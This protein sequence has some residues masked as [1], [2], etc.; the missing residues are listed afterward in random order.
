[1]NPISTSLK[2]LTQGNPDKLFPAENYKERLPTFTLFLNLQEMTLT[3]YK[4][5]KAVPIK[6]SYKRD[7]TVEMT[8][9]YSKGISPACIKVLLIMEKI[10]SSAVEIEIFEENAAT[11]PD[12]QPSLD[13]SFWTRDSCRFNAYLNPEKLMITEEFNKNSADRLLGLK[14]FQ[15]KVLEKVNPKIGEYVIYEK[16]DIS[17][18]AKVTG[19]KENTFELQIEP[20]QLF[21]LPTIVSVDRKQIVGKLF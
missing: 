13:D 3:S 9:S 2:A 6:Y 14:A 19:I 17:I 18:Y 11:P 15:P 16:Q 8:L 10:F 5:R 4:T 21:H 20:D 1:M 7:G 12:A